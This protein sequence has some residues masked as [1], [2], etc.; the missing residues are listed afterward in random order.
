MEKKFNLKLKMSNNFEVLWIVLQYDA[1]TKIV[2]TIKWGWRLND[3]SSGAKIVLFP[4]KKAQA[5]VE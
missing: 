3:S 1:T 5:E 2:I 4:W